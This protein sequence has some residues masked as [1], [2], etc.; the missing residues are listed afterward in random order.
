[1]SEQRPFEYWST[2]GGLVRFETVR[3]FQSHLFSMSSAAVARGD[4]LT[5]LLLA[6]HASHWK[7]WLPAAQLYVYVVVNAFNGLFNQK[8]LVEQANQILL[9]SRKKDAGIK[10]TTDLILYALRMARV[11]LRSHGIATRCHADWVSSAIRELRY[12]NR[13]HSETLKTTHHSLYSKEYPPS[14]RYCA[15]I[16]HARDVLLRAQHGRQPAKNQS[17]LLNG[18]VLF[19]A[20][21]F[22]IAIAWLSS[23]W[24]RFTGT[25]TFF[26]G[27]NLL[28]TALLAWPLLLLCTWFFGLAESSRTKTLAFVAPSHL[29]GAQ[30]ITV[31]EIMPFSRDW[32]FHIFQFVWLPFTA[33]GLLLFSKFEQLPE[34]LPRVWRRA[35]EDIESLNAMMAAMQPTFMPNLDGI[36]GLGGLLRSLVTSDLFA[37]LLAVIAS[38]AFVANQVRI[39]HQRRKAHINF[40]WWDIRVSKPEWIVRLSMVGLDAFLGAILLVK[41]LAVSLIA[42]QLVVSPHLSIAYFSPMAWEG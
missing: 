18:L 10:S 23:G 38:S 8:E 19:C 15:E 4:T 5:L 39:Q 13:A 35:P 41:V 37:L 34:Q 42:Y 27:Q 26:D 32:F 1:M 16:G 2:Y 22:S 21:T 7:Q 31:G 36:A 28:G 24:I 33:I 40:Y 3:E 11:V 25:S 14:Q 9:I 20:V 29:L 12:S 17:Q 6:E 30:P